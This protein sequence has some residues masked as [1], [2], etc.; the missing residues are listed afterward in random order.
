MVT[1]FVCYGVSSTKWQCNMSY[2]PSGLKIEMEIMVFDVIN[3]R[4]EI[5]DLCGPDKIWNFV[6]FSLHSECTF[7]FLSPT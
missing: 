6:L 1:L 2:M 3:I 4:K 5:I 7:V